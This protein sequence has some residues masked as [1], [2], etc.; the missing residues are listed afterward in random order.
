MYMQS[1]FGVVVFSNELARRY[2]DKGIVSTSLNPGNLTTNLGRHTPAAVMMLL[3]WLF[4]P[5]PYGALTQLY[6]GISPDTVNLNGEYLIPW[7]RVGKM[8]PEARN[9]E[10]GQRL[11]N[12][13][14]S[15]AK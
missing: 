7:A 12:W 5:A 13:L 11:W 8:R 10:L 3:R 1:K 6:A 14:E 9:P 15:E 2:G 4:S